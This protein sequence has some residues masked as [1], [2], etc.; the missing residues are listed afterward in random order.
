MSY[1]SNNS[2]RHTLP[3]LKDSD[4]KSTTSENVQQKPKEVIFERNPKAHTIMQ[5]A[6]MSFPNEKQSGQCFL[7]SDDPNAKPVNPEEYDQ[8]LQD[9]TSMLLIQFIHTDEFGFDVWRVVQLHYYG[10]ENDSNDIF[11]YMKELY[12]DN[13]KIVIMHEMEYVSTSEYDINKIHVQ[14]PENNQVLDYNGK[15][16]TEEGQI[17]FIDLDVAPVWFGANDRQYLFL[18]HKYNNPWNNYYIDQLLYDE[19]FEPFAIY[20]VSI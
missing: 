19:E 14:D 10:L 12:E 13:E 5:I 1:K 16:I 8:L 20:E 6:F 7:I 9:Y 17:E 15:E 18:I 11:E 3:K 2:F 4:A